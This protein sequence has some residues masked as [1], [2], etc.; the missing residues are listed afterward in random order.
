ME[1][2]GMPSHFPLFIKDRGRAA[3]D[4][5]ARATRARVRPAAGSRWAERAC[6]DMVEWGGNVVAAEWLRAA[7][8]P[9]A[10][11]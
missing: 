11:R 2:C 10:A 8:R 9:A 5:G 4:A 6:G 1:E 7:A 3:Y